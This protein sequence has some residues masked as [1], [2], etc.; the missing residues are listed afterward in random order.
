[1]STTVASSPRTMT[2]F[3]ISKAQKGRKSVIFFHQKWLLTGLNPVK[4]SGPDKIPTHFLKLCAEE[5]A[6]ALTLLYNQLEY[7]QTKHDGS[8]ININRFRR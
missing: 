7:M 8:S 2:K 6:D 4:A 3:Q 5:I 1:M